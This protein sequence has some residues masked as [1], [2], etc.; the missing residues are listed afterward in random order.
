MSKTNLHRLDEIGNG[1]KP[2]REIKELK[3]QGIIEIKRGNYNRILLDNHAKAVCEDFIKF[4]EKYDSLP[5]AVSE[6]EKK[7][8][9]NKADR[10]K[11]KVESRDRQIERIQNKLQVFRKPWYVRPLSWVKDGLKNLADKLPG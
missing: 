8:L 2:Y 6:Y 3:E 4:S 10:L 9:G 11:E 7:R 5:L 1:S